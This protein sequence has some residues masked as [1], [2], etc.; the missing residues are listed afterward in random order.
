M[1]KLKIS[2]RNLIEFILR[3]GDISSKSA[4]SS[5]ARLEEGTR[6]HVA[7]QKMRQQ[8]HPEYVKEYYL[9]YEVTIEGYDFIVDG[10]ADGI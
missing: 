9:K 2:V 1:T 10:R 6:A 3:S 5:P 8:S 4:G 7:H